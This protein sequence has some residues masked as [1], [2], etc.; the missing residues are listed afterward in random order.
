VIIV[1]TPLIRRVWPPQRVE[2]IP[3]LDKAQP[4]RGLVVLVSQGPGAETAERAIR[5][6]GSHLQWVWLVHSDA[7]KP[8]AQRILEALSQEI[9]LR[10]DRFTLIPLLDLNFEN[11][12][13]AVK[14]AIEEKVFRNLPSGLDETDV[15]V[16]I[17]GGRKATTAG[18][19]LAGLPRGRRLEVVNPRKIDPRRRG[20]VAD[21]PIEINIDYKV[22]RF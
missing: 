18:A 1:F 15:I 3:T 4:C 17:T 14:E 12:P 19:F 10:A 21:D 5:Y 7:S 22:K 11:L 9:K 13:E 16:D 6:H 2:F 20:T 8:D